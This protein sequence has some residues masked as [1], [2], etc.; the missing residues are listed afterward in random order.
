MPFLLFKGKQ[1]LI[2]YSL[3]ICGILKE[4]DE[5]LINSSFQKGDLGTLY[6]LREERMFKLVNI[7]FL[8]E[9]KNFY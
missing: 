6:M 1:I 7:E 9:A 3:I 8:S 5:S 4:K 2:E